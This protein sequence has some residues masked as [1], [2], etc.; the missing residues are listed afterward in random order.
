MRRY[1]IIAAVYTLLLFCG[2][3]GSIFLSFGRF[4][5]A[6]GAAEGSFGEKTE[7]ALRQSLPLRDPLRRWKTKLLMLGGGQE[8]DGIYFTGDGLIENL[9]VADEAVAGQNLTALAAFCRQREASVVL[10]PSACAIS[11]HLLP[12]AALLFDQEGWLQEAAAQLSADCGSVINGYPLLSEHES[13]RLFYRTDPRPTQLTGY[14]LYQALGETLDYIPYARERFSNTPLLYD[15][16]GSLYTRWSYDKVRADVVTALLPLQD[17]R[18]YR[19]LHTAPEG[20]TAAYSSLYPTEAAASANGMDCVLGGLSARIDVVA[21]GSRPR[22]LLLVGD[23]NA[24]CVIPYLALHY[25]SITFIDVTLCSEAMLDGL[26]AEQYD[27]TLL[28]YGTPT[29]LNDD[30]TGGLER[31][32]GAAVPLTPVP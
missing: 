1:R 7:A 12:E 29:L 23:E 22:S 13:S 9:T 25:E 3:L 11:R 19:M 10:L 14:L 27:R 26:A 17:S 4:T 31:L 2:L 28:L 21:Q 18:S 24:L 30:L 15:C 8:I 5:A 6:Y 16:Y 20:A 32:T